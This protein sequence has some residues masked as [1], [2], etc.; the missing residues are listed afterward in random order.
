MIAGWVCAPGRVPPERRGCTA[1]RLG[2]MVA[3]SRSVVLAIA[4]VLLLV[5]AG[6]SAGESDEPEAAGTS[7]GA[8]TGGARGTLGWEDCRGVEC[9]VL[10]VPL[11]PDDV[12][13]ATIELALA[14]R[15]A[16][17]ER[18]GSLLVNP[19]GPGSEARWLAFQ[20][21][22]IFPDRVLE[23]FDIVAWD[24]RGVGAST[25]VN[26][27]DDLEPFWAAD[28]SPD[29][30]AELVE[31][32]RVSREL[33]EGCG[34]RSAELL[35]HLSS[36]ATVSDMDRIREALGDD[37]LNYLG[38]SYGT[39]LGARY[40]ERYPDRVRS[41]VLDGAID[42]SL[43]TAEATRQ[44]ALGFE[45]SLE[46]FL[47]AC[48][49]DDGCAFHAGGDP[50]RGYDRL[51]TQ[52]DAEALPAE[53][54]GES[55][56]LGPGEADIGV[57]AALYAGRDGWERLGEALNAAARGDGALLLALAD[58]YTGYE[59]DGRYS[60][61]NEA[62]Y[63][64]GCLDGPVPTP[65]EIETQAEALAREAPRFGPATVWLGLP[66]AYWP[67]EGEVETE[68]LRA[69]RA[70][71]ILV[72]GTANDPATP[73]AWAEALTDQLVSGVLAVLD[74]E[75]HTAFGRGNACID[76]IVVDYLVD[77]EVPV[78]GATCPA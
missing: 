38:F 1:P 23:H 33:A 64:T 70:P 26:C 75:G 37:Q 42:P 19:G 9:A 43:P 60:D 15:P 50:A 30:A 34:E 22:L 13:G 76:R 46:A 36:W 11:D 68:D 58:A 41:L 31:V 35:P 51:M 48:A 62:F 67:V 7:A 53:L 78:R 24:P 29:D 77:L 6:C 3:R 52:I 16:E 10:E 61:E 73:L 21:E 44:Q 2:T 57:A 39:L 54:D 74:D 12:A 40:A 4:L 28:R 69:E 32:A 56:E 18:I 65:G 63:A 27:L 59:G 66:C 5:A 20:A 45:A 17:G 72:L 25:S 14:R 55:R 71:P 47:D 49:D 8:S